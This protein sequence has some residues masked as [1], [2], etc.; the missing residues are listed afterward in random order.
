MEEAILYDRTDLI[1]KEAFYLYCCRFKHVPLTD[2]ITSYFNHDKL[3]EYLK[4]CVNRILDAIME[5]KK[6]EGLKWILRINKEKLGN[7][8]YWD[9]ERKY[10]RPFYIIFD[11]FLRFACI[12]K[13]G[14]EIRKDKSIE[15]FKWSY[16]ENPFIAKFNK[17]MQR[18]INSLTFGDDDYFEP[19]IT[20]DDV[21]THEQ[22]V[23]CCDETVKRDF[24][25][26]ALRKYWN[27]LRYLHD[28]DFI[29]DMGVSRLYDGDEYIKYID[30]TFYYVKDFKLTDE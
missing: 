18:Y 16:S 28:E 15:Y 24:Q 5:H 11:H 27:K 13:T 2:S 1:N 8:I 3:M 25:N 22:T 29:N 20:P 23:A 10:Q 21:F 14:I 7:A 26:K 19:F 9:N 4:Y 6:H 17:W 12:F 30:A